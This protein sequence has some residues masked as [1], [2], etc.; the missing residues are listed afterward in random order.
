MPRTKL[1]V[2]VLV[3]S[4]GGIGA[5][6]VWATGPSVEPRVPEVAV[7][8]IRVVV[9]APRDVQ[10]RVLTHGTVAPRTESDLI[11][12]V[13]GPVVWVSPSL[14]SGGFFAADEELLHVDPTDYDVALERAR[15]DLARAQSEHNLASR[16]LERRRGLAQRNV[17]SAAELDATLNAE[18]SAAAAKRAA[19]AVLRKA[20]RDLERTR[21]RAPYD[22]RVREESVDVGQFISRGA[23]I[24]KLYAVDF[25]EVRLPVPDGELAYL[26]LPLLYRENGA[27]GV[28]PEVRLRAR[29]AGGE[30]DWRGRIVRTEGEIDPKSRMVHVVARV[31][32]PYGRET[33]SDRPPL[34]VGLFVEAEI[35]GRTEPDAIVLPRA[36]MRGP[37]RVLV[38]DGEGRLHFRDVEVARTTRDEVVIRQGLAPG[39]RVCVSPLETVVEGMRVRV[40]PDASGV[41]PS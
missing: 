32:D 10:L 34:A 15:A 28:E 7:P 8:L 39:E 29:F 9:A 5:V 22:G 3:V 27:A 25:A 14:V 11:P 16:D 12:E 1:L 41:P 26:D 24:A 36:A 30:Y 6:V 19:R 33:A 35:L 40:A 20:E 13:S 18:R 37:S 17:A 2:P 4:L 23:P 21:I 38:V 31:E